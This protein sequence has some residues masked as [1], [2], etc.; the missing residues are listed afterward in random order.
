MCYKP[1]TTKEREM[2]EFIENNSKAIINTLIVV[3]FFLPVII[4][5]YLILLNFTFNSGQINSLFSMFFIG[6][7]LL[8]IANMPEL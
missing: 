5:L 6:L 3:I 2:K 4:S 7:A 1:N 8:F